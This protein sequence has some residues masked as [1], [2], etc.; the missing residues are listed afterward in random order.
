VQA[1]N[2]DV[3]VS[4]SVG[5]PL[6]VEEFNSSLQLSFRQGCSYPRHDPSAE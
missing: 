4:F 1:A 3:F 6:T 2:E 5:L